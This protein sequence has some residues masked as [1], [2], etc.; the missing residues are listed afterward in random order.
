[1][2]PRDIRLALRIQGDHYRW[3]ITLEDAAHYEQHN[4]RRIDE[5][6]QPIILWINSTK[7]Y[8][9]Y[10]MYATENTYCSI[11]CYS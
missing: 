2:I 8:L 6:S 11:Y 3:H 4:K 7:I 10:I 9:F 1:M 5:G